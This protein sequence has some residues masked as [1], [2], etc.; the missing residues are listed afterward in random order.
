MKPISLCLTHMGNKGLEL[1]KIYPDILPENLVNEIVLKSMP[2]SSKEGDF[3]SS[4]AQDCVFESYIFTV[5]GDQRNNIASLVAVFNNSHYN[6]DN[7]RKFFSFTVQE[8]KKHNLGD[9]E[10]FERILPNMFD[11]LT[12][13]KVK[14][15]ISSVVSLDFDFEEEEKK[16]KDRGEELLDSLKG[17]MWK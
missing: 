5:P 14:I 17:D 7:V 16:P 1:L 8:L 10:T 13:G 11:G 9:T 6:R 3:A 4:T 12:K 2:L 15:K